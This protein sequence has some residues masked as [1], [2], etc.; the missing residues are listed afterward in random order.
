MVERYLVDFEKELKALKDVSDEYCLMVQ[1]AEK[2]IEVIANALVSAPLSCTVVWNEATFAF[3]ND[4]YIYRIGCQYSGAYN[5]LVYQRRVEGSDWGELVKISNKTI[6]RNEFKMGVAYVLP[7]LL[8]DITKIV[9]GDV[10]KLKCAIAM[11][12]NPTKA[13]EPNHK[14]AHRCLDKIAERIDG[15]AATIDNGIK[16]EIKK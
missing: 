4:G 8:R 11:I 10:D 9:K 2:T 3:D 16:A 14:N 15:W 1:E 5:G 12:K 6:S 7:E 13:P